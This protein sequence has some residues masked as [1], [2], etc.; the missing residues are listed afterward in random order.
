MKQYFSDSEEHLEC[1]SVTR[2]SFYSDMTKKRIS[3]SLASLG[4]SAYWIMR[5]GRQE[6]KRKFLKS[7]KIHLSV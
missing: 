7:S 5:A 2:V 3:I 1:H 4:T 6:T